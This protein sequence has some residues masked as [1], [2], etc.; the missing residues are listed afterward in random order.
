[1]AY[2]PMGLAHAGLSDSELWRTSSGAFLCFV[3]IGG[4]SMTQRMRALP[5]DV[6]S[7]MNPVVRGMS[8]ATWILTMLLLLLNL[9]G[10]GF[11]PQ[12]VPYFVGL[13]LLLLNGSIQFTRILF[14]RPE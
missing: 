8:I 9:S 3:L 10:L 5:D 6:R 12:F 13:V 7:V 4:A 11:K 1:M 14:V 2:L